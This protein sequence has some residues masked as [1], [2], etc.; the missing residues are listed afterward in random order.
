MLSINLQSVTIMEECALCPFGGAYLLPRRSIF[1]P[2][3]ENGDGIYSHSIRVF[4]DEVIGIRMVSD[5]YCLILLNHARPPLRALCS[6]Q[7]LLD[8]LKGQSF[9]R[10]AYDSVLNLDMVNTIY[11][12]GVVVGDDFYDVGERFREDVME[13]LYRTEPDTREKCADL[14]SNG[15]DWFV[16]VG[17]CA[18]RVRLAEVGWI[19]VEGNVSTLHFCDGRKPLHLS[20]PLKV[21]Q[22]ELP[23]EHFLKINK[24][25]IINHHL[26]D[27]IVTQEP[28]SV[29]LGQR[30]F[31][32]SR[33]YY[34]TLKSVLHLL[35]ASRLSNDCKSKK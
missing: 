32:V 6:L 1:V 21:W 35:H 11:S 13:A 14:W 29:F 19:E 8:L 17:K 2:Q 9:V 26:V 7:D 12:K 28:Y 10:I 4:L 16:H 33:P 31:Q 5:K 3:D 24:S 22:R 34:H 18:K 30:S 20:I 15:N 25:V 23:P 27:T